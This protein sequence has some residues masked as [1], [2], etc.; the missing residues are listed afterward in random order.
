MVGVQFHPEYT[1]EMVR[2]F[3]REESEEWQIDRF[4]AGKEAVLE[5]TDKLSFDTYGLMAKLLDNMERE[6]SPNL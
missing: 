6:F 1:C 4:V 2:Y 3:A 5:Q